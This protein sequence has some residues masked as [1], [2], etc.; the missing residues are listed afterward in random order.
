LTG[1]SSLLLKNNEKGDFSPAWSPDGKLIAYNRNDGIYVVNTD[2]SNAHNISSPSQNVSDMPDQ[3]PVWSPNSQQIAFR[4]T[5]DGIEQVYV[6]NVDGSGLTRLSD[7]KFH[8]AMDRVIV[9]SPDGTQLAFTARA[10]SNPQSGQVM[11]VNADGSNLHRLAQGING[12]T[13]PSWSKNGRLAFEV[14]LSQS[15]QNVYVVDA[16]GGN[17]RNLTISPPSDTEPIWQP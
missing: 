4:S 16:T 5:R 2:G 9:W 17:L 15:Q 8:N 10:N 7:L 3:S 12:Q 6:V 14:D 1:T 11:L 13:N